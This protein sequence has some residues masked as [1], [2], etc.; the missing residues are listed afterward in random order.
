MKQSEFYD[1]KLAKDSESQS[2][3]MERYYQLHAKIYD[4]T[5]WTFL[6]GRDALVKAL[7]FSKEDEI[8]ILEVGC[9]TGYNLKSIAKRF[10][11]ATLMALDVSK[12]MLDKTS[13]KLED[14][15]NKC[16][17][18]NQPYGLDFPP[19]PEQ[20][21]LV[22]FSYS[23]T[24]INPHWDDLILQAKKDLKPGG[25]VAAVDFHDSPS[26]GFKKHMGNNHVR[27][28]GHILPFLQQHFEDQTAEVKN[29][30]FGWWHYFM[31][32]GSKSS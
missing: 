2:K 3:N 30:Y 6:F 26:K 22:I 31:Y 21:D 25:I 5:R 28:D 1:K 20:P 10:P 13:K 32:I 27:M 23:L 17:Y 15:P 12:D 24:M 4:L 19:I 29:A 18:L 14:K 16:L 11:K 7:P 9:G 8:T